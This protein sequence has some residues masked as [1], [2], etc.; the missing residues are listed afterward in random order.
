LKRRLPIRTVALGLALFLAV[1]MPN[2]VGFV[3]RLGK[4]ALPLTLAD[5]VLAL[6][7]AGVVL[8][9]L[10]SR[11]RGMRLPPVAAFL[12]VAAGIVA[13]TRTEA[14]A[15][16][17]A[18]KEVLQLIEYFLVAYFVFVN[19]AET[20]DL[21]PLLVAFGIGAAIVVVWGGIQYAACD[22]A[23]DVK[24]GF[25]GGNHNV[26]GAYLAVAL[27]FL[28]GIAVSSRCWCTAVGL[29]VLVVA[30]LAINLS[31]GPL[32]AALV[33]LAVV[34]AIRGTRALV[35]YLVVLG[36]AVTF[37]PRL[38]PRP[39]HSDTL[40]SSAALLVDDNYL[41]SDA[42]LAARAQELL[43]PTQPIPVDKSGTKLEV[44]TPRPLDA[45]RLLRLLNGRRDLTHEEGQLQLK[46]ERAKAK[47]ST[48]EQDA[49]ALGEAQVARRYQRWNAAL[50]TARALWNADRAARPNP[51]SDPFFGCGLAPYHEHVK[52]YMDARLQYRTDEP[53]V[54]NIAAPEPFTHNLWLKTMVQTGLVGLTALV[55][56]LSGFLGRAV[57]LYR[58]AQGELALGVAL[59]TVGAILG[60][61]LGGMFTQG[62]VRGLAIPFVFVL[63]T[64]VYRG[65]HRAWRQEE[66]HRQDDAARLSAVPN[67]W[68]LIFRRQSRIL[69]AG[70]RWLARP[71]AWTLRPLAQPCVELPDA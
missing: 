16:G 50:I 60:F 4:M 28:Y 56:L 53:E 9:L 63:A 14:A 47:M 46:A 69:A 64:G 49:Y 17:E 67:I 7:F 34:S 57:R 55:W 42:Q 10:S 8:H 5:V 52:P 15:R 59:G 54:F 58:A 48:R 13:L 20:G 51:R 18:V 21:K 43:E 70:E 19:V 36:V 3:V 35:P 62:I 31:G 2:Q 29:M 26:L 65:T 12:I 39:H 61:A 38:L 6:A 68:T 23:L 40:V 24:A 27:P 45:A 1:I 44:P 66:R 71:A 22:S 11:F 37:G 30:G 41:L 33:A 25:L 32:A